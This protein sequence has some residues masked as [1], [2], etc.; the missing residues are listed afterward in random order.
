V[1]Q[2]IFWRRQLVAAG[3]KIARDGLSVAT[4]EAA[5]RPERLAKEIASAGC[6][7]GREGRLL[8]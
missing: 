2:S 8:R 6:R 4:T 1:E 5:P 3:K 7:K